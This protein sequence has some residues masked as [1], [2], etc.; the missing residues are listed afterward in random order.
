[1]SDVAEAL[2]L[3]G[4]IA[5][6]RK[7]IIK[8]QAAGTDESIKFALEGLE[9]EMDVVVAK[10][11]ELEA[12]GSAS[13]ETDDSSL[14]KYFVGKV[15]KEFSITGK[16]KYEKVATQKVKLVLKARD[17]D[18]NTPELSSQGEKKVDY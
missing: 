1:M 2:E 16:G 11:L 3:S 4:V 13:V 6:L 5:G 14:L 9:I 7:E 18:G 12:K 8:A 17:A 10:S 15:K